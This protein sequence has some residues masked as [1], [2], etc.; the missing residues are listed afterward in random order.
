MNSHA[1]DM[2]VYMQ[3]PSMVIGQVCS[4][5]ETEELAFTRTSSFFQVTYEENVEAGPRGTLIN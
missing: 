4:V 3:R 5:S 2:T 1:S